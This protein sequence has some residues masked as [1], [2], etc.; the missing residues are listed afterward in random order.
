MVGVQT[1]LMMH[2]RPGKGKG[3]KLPP[4]LL[5]VL[6][7]LLFSTA[8]AIVSKIHNESSFYYNALPNQKIFLHSLSIMCVFH[9]SRKPSD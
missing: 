2:E 7:F 6:S 8:S 3:K 9:V 1:F 4:H 5:Y